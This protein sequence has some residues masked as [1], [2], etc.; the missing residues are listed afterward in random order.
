MGRAKQTAGIVSRYLGIKATTLRGLL[1]W[2][3][4]AL[5]GHPL[6]EVQADMLKLIESPATTPA[7]GESFH[8]FTAR[9]LG[10]LFAL[11]EYAK[12]NGKVVAAITHKSNTQLAKAWLEEGAHKDM[13][14]D[15]ELMAE[16][17]EPGHT[18]N[19]VKPGDALVLSP[20]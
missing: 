8:A 13:G 4:G 2:N 5:A 11:L 1:P 12:A 17:A 7:G 3:V 14:Y 10:C 18:E 16:Y 9:F 20:T 6:R 19:A 15:L